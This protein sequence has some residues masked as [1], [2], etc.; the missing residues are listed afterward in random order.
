M[1]ELSL[2]RLLGAS[3]A[4]ARAGYRSSAAMAAWPSHDDKVQAT[5]GTFHDKVQATEGT[6]HFCRCE[7]NLLDTVE[8][9]D[10]CT[11]GVHSGLPGVDVI[12]S[13]AREAR[14]NW[15]KGQLARDMDKLEASQEI[16]DARYKK[17]TEEF[18]NILKAKEAQ[19]RHELE[20]IQANRAALQGRVDK[21][22]VERDF[23]ETELVHAT[24]TRICKAPT[25]CVVS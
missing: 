1:G 14:W 20:L 24:R 18:L 2:A 5:E 21:W 8:T 11:L 9:I 7:P 22:K 25:E 3:S 17:S 10:A 13:H 12:Q 15:K 23:H 4:H 16:V 19:A 6:F